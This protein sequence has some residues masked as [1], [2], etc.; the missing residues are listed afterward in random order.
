MVAT[1]EDVRWC[2]P[3]A[4]YHSLTA[5]TGGSSPLGSASDF[6]YLV[7]KAITGVPE[8][9][10]RDLA[11]DGASGAFTNQFFNPSRVPLR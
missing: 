3:M 5:K 6:K 10:R 11:F 2:P 7:V 4:Y 8:V 1:F 9:S